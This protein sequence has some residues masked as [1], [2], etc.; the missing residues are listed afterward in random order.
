M[1]VFVCALVMVMGPAGA[2]RAQSGGAVAGI[3]TDETGGVLPGV[4]VDLDIGES[5]LTAVSGPTGEYRIE[6]VPAR[7]AAIT[8]RLVNFSTA[9]QEVTVAAGETL[10]VNVTLSLSLTADVVMTGTRTFR[11]I[12]D[13][14]NPR[15]SLV[16]RHV[17]LLG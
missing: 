11:N 13:L 16:L 6:G 7:P 2:A 15:E 4:V 3:V 17:K 5:V 1:S 8:F 12:A 14:E 10:E 9:R